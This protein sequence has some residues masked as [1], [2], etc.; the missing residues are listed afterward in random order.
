MFKSSQTLYERIL[1]S[2]A[3]S[4]IGDALGCATEM[5]T[6][7]DI[8]ATY[9]DFVNELIAPYEGHPLFPDK[10]PPGQW[11]D[12]AS[13]LIKMAEAVI[14]SEGYLTFEH[15]ADQLL[16]WAELPEYACAGP[17]TIAAINALKSGVNPRM[18][19]RTGRLAADG[20]S[21]GAAM[22][23]SPAGLANPGDLDGAV[24]DSITMTVPTHG[25]SVAVE[26][27]AAIA[28][29]VAQALEEEATVASVV[30]A[31]LYGAV[32]GKKRSKGL[33]R[34]VPSPSV[35]K[36]T[37]LAVDLACRNSDIYKTM[38]DLEAYVG[39]G[40][41]I[42][43]TVP[44]AIGLFVAANGDPFTTV[45]A[46]AN[47]G[48]DTDTIATIAGALAGALRG[49]ASVPEHLYRQ[50]VEVNQ[51]DL[52]GISKAIVEVIQKRHS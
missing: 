7:S 9:G 24:G 22:K 3:T 30:Q 1:G 19:G 23:V 35:Y 42:Y 25:T 11:T 48:N 37:E 26:G 28:A 10:R 4:C 52:E 51:V 36:R 39:T 5:L 8:K 29:G 15:V 46:A 12:D 49:F 21:N 47:I 34:Q 31:C 45:Y 14:A 20:V 2:L 27:A 18:S 32:E 33:V 44:T 6:M 41:A 43:E 50:V 40:L 16:R 17:S 38:A 13:L